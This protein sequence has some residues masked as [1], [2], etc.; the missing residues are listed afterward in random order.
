MPAVCTAQFLF[1]GGSDITVP[2]RSA[3]RIVNTGG[4]LVREPEV[5]IVK[6]FW[7]APPRRDIRGRPEC[8][9]GNPYPSGRFQEA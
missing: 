8:C 9:E 3:E 6:G 2:I 7:P 4:E 5:N 1:H